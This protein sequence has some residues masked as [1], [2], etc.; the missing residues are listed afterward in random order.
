MS[1]WQR[2]VLLVR[3]IRTGGAGLAALLRLARLCVS[4]YFL[5]FCIWASYYSHR[6][7]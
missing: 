5:F 6:F 7:S 4:L 3:G 1:N 2:G